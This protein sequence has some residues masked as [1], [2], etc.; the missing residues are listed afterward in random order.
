M[1]A[2]HSRWAT[3]FGDRGF[4]TAVSP[5]NGPCASACAILFLTGRHSVIAGRSLLVF[6]MGR[7]AVT[8]ETMPTEIIDQVATELTKYGLTKRQSWAL[9][10][11]APPEGGRLATEAW[12]RQLGIRYEVVPNFL[13][14]WQN[15]Q[16]KFCLA[17]P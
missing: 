15:C 6:H 2:R 14:L 4:N 16:A 11:A 5:T 3:S 12:A 9:L 10:T 13:W 8:G 1:P 17:L 7:D